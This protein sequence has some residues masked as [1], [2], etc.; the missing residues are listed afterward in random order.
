MKFKPHSE[1]PCAQG[2]EGKGKFKQ[3]W[4]SGE[5]VEESALLRKLVA[6]S[7]P[8]PADREEHTACGHAVFSTSC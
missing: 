1:L 7:A 6:P 8:T 3:K 2:A 5:D 4:S